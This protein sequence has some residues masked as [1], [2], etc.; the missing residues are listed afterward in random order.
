MAFQNLLSLCYK[1]VNSPHMRTKQ[2]ATSKG[3]PSLQFYKTD[4]LV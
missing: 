1:C 3:H 4:G 2:L